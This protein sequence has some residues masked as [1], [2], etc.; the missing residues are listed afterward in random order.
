MVGSI[1][2]GQYTAIPKQ[3]SQQ[4]FTTDFNNVCRSYIGS[5]ISTFAESIIEL[6]FILQEHL[7]L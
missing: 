4:V 5:R 3:I 2:F 6:L 1:N 7:L